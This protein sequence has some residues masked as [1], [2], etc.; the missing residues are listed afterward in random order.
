L[1]TM[2]E[3]WE[4]IGLD[5]TLEARPSAIVPAP[6]IGAALL[7]F[8]R[9]HWED[10]ERLQWRILRD[11]EGLRHARLYGKRGQAQ[12]GLDIVALAPDEVG[13]ALQ[14]KRYEQFG[15]SDLDAAVKKFR[16]TDRPFD[17][18]RFIIGV[19]CEAK[20]TAVVEALAA[21]QIALRPVKLELWDEEELSAILR[22]QPEIVIQFFG[23]PT[24]ASFCVPFVF[25][26][27]EVPAADA[28]LVREA[29]GRTPEETT[30]AA[31]SFRAAEAQRDDPARALTLIE[32]GQAYLRQAGFGAHAAQYEERRSR[33]LVQ[34]GRAGEAARAALDE[35]WAALDQ[36][37]TTNAEILAGRLRQLAAGAPEDD[38]VGQLANVA[39]AA[40]SLNLNPLG[41]LP[42]LDALAEGDANDQLRLVV[43]A[44]E[45]ALAN[46]QLDWLTAASE[47][48]TEVAGQSTTDR[49]YRVRARL[50]LA[51][52]TDDWARVLED[53]RKLRLGHDLG[54]LVTARYARHRALQQRFEEADV[55]WEEAA[56]DACLA[57]RWADA[58][59]WVF[60]RRA[61]RTRWRLTAQD[62]L[63]ALEIALGEMG[64]SE[65]VVPRDERAY[66][67]A[68]ADLRTHNLRSAAIA[69]QRSL[70]NAVAASDWVGEER[71]RR[72]LGA[73]LAA[74]DEPELAA[75]HL[76]R[77]A[78][79]TAMKDLA[80]KNTATYIDIAE[81]LDAPN[82]WTVGTAYR[83]IAAEADLV[84]DGALDGI[85]V[86]IL[87]ELSSAESHSV[88]DAGGFITSRYLGAVKALAGLADRLAEAQGEAVLAHFERQPTL[89]P[90]EYRFHDEDEA[91]IVAGIALS[92][93]GL[94]ERAI[95]HL[96]P[97]LA[98]SQPAR[99][100]ISMR[101]IDS[102]PQ[103]ALRHLAAEAEA[104]S[105]WAREVLAARDDSD[106]PLAIAQAAL[107]RLTIPLEHVPGL[108]TRGTNAIGDS[109]L[110]GTL[111]PAQRTLA[112]DELLR[113]AED[114]H[115]AIADR[116]DYLLA[117]SNLVDGL[118]DE[119]RRGHFA[120]AMHLTTSPTP[121]QQGEFED[122][123]AHKL[124][125]FRMVP[126]ENNSQAKA[127]YLAACLADDDAQ[128]S[129][130][131]QHAYALLG[132]S[133]RSDYWP[134][135]VLQCLGDA[136]NDDLGFL[137]G[138]GWALRSLAAI[139]WAKR[140]VP[141][142]VG[143]RLATDDDARVRRALASALA[144][145]EPTP[146][147]AEARQLL[148]EDAAYSVRFLLRSG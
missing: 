60:S 75:H 132:S 86:R 101:A 46:D 113:R 92:L 139:L 119:V 14:S 129:E 40:I 145:V 105:D 112:I 130:I 33:V 147:Q 96:V 108:Y 6:V 120:T 4:P 76:A 25:Q 58:S 43:L 68:L 89:T 137:S 47:I 128:R 24:A 53:A 116:G 36:G 104:G 34:L 102:A 106:T 63:L 67:T 138:Q 134:T 74:S 144:D 54:A 87:A 15:V 80:D 22:D 143:R 17:V 79:T 107:E 28:V 23:V 29:L 109:L 70:R 90:N 127:L 32:Q 42:S 38:R 19:G 1:I 115:V 18:E 117:A 133:H 140:S 13:V 3:E 121:S 39:E 85:A 55:L 142:H 118:G 21:H 77:G 72:V 57:R 37:K 31:E 122:Q 84:P 94:R 9:L 78:D 88:P 141:A 10:L 148:K 65:S 8:D 123:F 66:T 49:V 20:S 5:S 45:T 98:R 100:D 110:V 64:P 135:R 126:G 131:K 30:G 81:S 114:P 51:E 11:V 41:R 59:T 125:S 91:T 83:L 50:L 7:P 27:I 111:A 62:E 95:A 52:A 146:E 124:G 61:F 44:G 73:I 16:E 71:T 82:Y 35:I 2:G 12:H 56:G 69:A 26:T 97:L 99:S 103:V 48:L 93:P 136:L